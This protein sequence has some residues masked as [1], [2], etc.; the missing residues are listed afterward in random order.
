MDGLETG[1]ESLSGLKPQYIDPTT[2]YVVGFLFD[3]SGDKVILMEKNRP[4]WQRGRF[5][6]VGGKIE[7]ADRST[8]EAM[9]R[10]GIEEIGVSPEWTQFATVAYGFHVLHFFAV[11]DQ[12]AFMDA[13]RVTDEKIFR[14]STMVPWR[15]RLIPNLNW[16]LPMARHHLFYERVISAEI[17]MMGN[18]STISE[19]Q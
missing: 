17:K 18:G 10:E 11:R 6:G 15:Q 8:L 3:D 19:L 14:M 13:R 1:T 9:I 7:Q 16:L 4:A 12:V 2:H 5:N